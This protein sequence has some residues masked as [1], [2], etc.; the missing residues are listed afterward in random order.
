MDP[1]LV[2]CLLND[3]AGERDKDITATS[4]CLNGKVLLLVVNTR[5]SAK[6]YWGSGYRIFATIKYPTILFQDN[7]IHAMCFVYGFQLAVAY[8]AVILF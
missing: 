7:L 8:H 1:S 3:T 6:P 5:A 4:S 2:L